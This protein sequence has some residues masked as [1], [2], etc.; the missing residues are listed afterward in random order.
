MSTVRRIGR[1]IR[2]KRASRQQPESPMEA[3]QQ[4]HAQRLDRLDGARRAVADLAA[5]R[6][7]VEV[8]AERTRAE[9]AHLDQQ[10]EAAVAAGDEVA[11]REHLRRSVIAA[12]RLED[13]AAQHHRLTEQVRG[14]ESDLNRLEHQAEDSYLRAQSLRADHDAARAALARREDAVAAGRLEA[15]GLERDAADRI[16]RLQAEAEAY[17]EIAGT[18]P[19]SEPVRAAFDELGTDEDVNLR[20]EAMRRRIDPPRH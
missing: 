20:L 14:L 10:A 13:L 1:L 7:R 3:L 4:A 6:R 19:G 9:I 17:E 12:G 16:R 15:S 5:S 8:L 11:A 2:S 18:D